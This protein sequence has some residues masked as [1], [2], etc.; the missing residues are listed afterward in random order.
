MVLR[1]QLIALA[2]ACL[3]AAP[4]WADLSGNLIPNGDFE[5]DPYDT[6]IKMTDSPKTQAEVDAGVDPI[7]SWQFHSGG[8]AAP[9]QPNEGEWFDDW[10]KWIGGFAVSLHDDPRAAFDQGYDVR[11]I[12][13]SYIDTDGDDVPDNHVMEEVYQR[14]GQPGIFLKAPDNH[15]PGAARLD[16]DF[17]MDYWPDYVTPTPSDPP[18]IMHAYLFGVP[19]TGVPSWDMRWG[20]ASH[21]V[22]EVPTENDRLEYPDPLGWEK[23]YGTPHFSNWGSGEDPPYTHTSD[24][25]VNIR[26]GSY[27]LGS[28]VSLS[29]GWTGSLPPHTGDTRYTDGNFTADTYYPYYYLELWTCVYS[30]P[31]EYWWMYDPYKLVDVMSVAFDN[32]ELELQVSVPGDFNNDGVTNLLDIN[33]FVLAIT[34]WDGG[35]GSYMDTYPYAHLP[36]I[37]PSQGAES[38]DPVVNLLDINYF[39]DIVTGSGVAAVPEPASLALL[40]IGGLALLRR[41]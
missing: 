13:R 11:P 30:E 1:R 14:F 37:D 38:G 16:F 10:S 26:D 15:I 21:P 23:V 39:V 28:W 5:A 31:H 33:D 34:N 41:R 20:P 32:I 7:R 29:D 17:Y 35:T 24:G 9:G 4:S 6:Y 25:L 27:P 12:N 22:G 3:F 40:A 8:T 18:I 2:V 36:T 19:D